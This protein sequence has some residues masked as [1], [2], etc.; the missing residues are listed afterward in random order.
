MFKLFLAN[1]TAYYLFTVCMHV[2]RHFMYIF[3]PFCYVA[4]M[5]NSAQLCGFFIQC[6]QYI[7]LPLRAPHLSH[8][9][10]DPQFPPPNFALDSWSRFQGV[11]GGRLQSK[12]ILLT[13]LFPHPVNTSIVSP[14]YWPGFEALCLSSCLPIHLSACTTGF[15]T[16]MLQRWEGWNICGA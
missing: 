8:F 12:D 16:L 7:V 1:I 9:L 5:I 11:E 3:S 2:E 4:Q 15:M 6:M 13:W 14:S 10:W